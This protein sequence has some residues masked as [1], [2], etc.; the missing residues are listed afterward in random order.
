MSLAHASHG[1]DDVT[2]KIEFC[3]KCRYKIFRQPRLAGRCEAAIRAVAERHLIIIIE[4]S[5]MQEHVHCIVRAFSRYSLSYITPL[6]KGGSAYSMF[7]EFP[8]LCLGYPRGSLWVLAK[9]A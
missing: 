9:P 5:V 4:L 2:Y 7:R 1:I 6:L 8:Q 3:T